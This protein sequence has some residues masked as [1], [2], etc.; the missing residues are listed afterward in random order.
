[1]ISQSMTEIERRSKPWPGRVLVGFDGSPNSVVAI[2]WA[3][4]EV[5]ARG[6][7]LRLGSSASRLSCLHHH[8]LADLHRQRLCAV[9]HQLRAEHPSLVVE[10]ASTHGDPRQAL[11]EEAG[12][13]DLLVLAAS[14]NEP[15]HTVLLGSLAQQAMRRSPC[16]VVVVRGSR[17]GPVRRIVLGID[18]SGADAA[19]DWA[20]VETN[21]HRADLLVVQSRNDVISGAEAEC[22]LDLAVKEC[23][24]R[25]GERVR[26]A[27]VE[28]S[29]A[30][31]LIDAS[32]TADLVAVASRECTGFKTAAVS[33]MAL[34][35]AEGASCP[36]AVT[37]P[38][39]PT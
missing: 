7:A 34:K 12:D 14:T 22:V 25:T 13:A 1:M 37:H 17:T 39:N 36:V 10:L 20:C 5:A 28:R 18:G 19:L 35:V 27:L 33:S 26:G 23:R 2:E 30:S 38:N 16:P 31:A 21:L 9:L 8:G 11:I 32:R 24:A 29:L 15:A 4:R 6:S 3:I